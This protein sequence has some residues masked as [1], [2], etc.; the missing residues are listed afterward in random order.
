[1]VPRAHAPVTDDSAHGV[2]A[3]LLPLLAAQLQYVLQPLA[4]VAILHTHRSHL[5]TH[6]TFCYTV[7][8]MGDPLTCSARNDSSLKSP[9]RWMLFSGMSISMPT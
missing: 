6:L 9:T 3:R 5:V 7:K 4:Q 8:I 2:V 1:M